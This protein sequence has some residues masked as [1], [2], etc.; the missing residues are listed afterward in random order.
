MNKNGSDYKIDNVFT[1]VS[2]LAGK[3][4]EHATKRQQMKIQDEPTG[5]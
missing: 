2:H 5:I 3:I 4:F 1:S